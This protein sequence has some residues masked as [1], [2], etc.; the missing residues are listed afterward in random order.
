MDANNILE[1]S[2]DNEELPDFDE[3]NKSSQN[4]STFLSEMSSENAEHTVCNEHLYERRVSK[5]KYN[6]NINAETVRSVIIGPVD[7][8]NHLARKQRKASTCSIANNGFKNDP[9][10]SEL[11]QNTSTDDNEENIIMEDSSDEEEENSTNCSKEENE[12]QAAT[13]TQFDTKVNIKMPNEG[14][15]KIEIQQHITHQYH[16]PVYQ[17]DA[18]T[19]KQILQAHPNIIAQICDRDMAD[20]PKITH[21]NKLSNQRGPSYLR[22]EDDISIPI[23]EDD[24]KRSSDNKKWERKSYRKKNQTRNDD[25]PTDI[26]KVQLYNRGI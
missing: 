8:T 6:T 25:L 14:P 1:D 24:N 19:T 17:L 13:K 10:E 23:D 2:D 20:V 15:P 7:E 16:G 9:T 5:D 3:T 11:V 4:M 12:P 22:R 26:N 18:E 21:K